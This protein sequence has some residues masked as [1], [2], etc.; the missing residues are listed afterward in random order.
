MSQIDIS[1]DSK[2][3]IIFIVLLASLILNN[4]LPLALAGD[5][6]EEALLL[7]EIGVPLPTE[8]EHFAKGRWCPTYQYINWPNDDFIFKTHNNS[9]GELC[10][11][12]FEI[13]EEIKKSIYKIEFVEGDFLY[14]PI[15]YGGP[16]GTSVRISYEDDSLDGTNQA[17]DK[18]SGEKSP[19]KDTNDNKEQSNQS[20]EASS[21]PTE[22]QK[23][24]IFTIDQTYTIPTAGEKFIGNIGWERW[25]FKIEGEDKLINT[26]SSY[27]IKVVSGSTWSN[28]EKDFR[29]T[30]VL[31]ERC[32]C[33]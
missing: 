23:N 21:E 33:D 30:V 29:P 24:I 19:T 18:Q 5:K 11:A 3:L 4:F 9:S 12:G 10:K 1:I 32:E 25:W 8:L 27:S 16:K 2:A 20:S 7:I 26:H 14:G 6:D 31:Y 13:K 15:D 28:K 17:N 22:I